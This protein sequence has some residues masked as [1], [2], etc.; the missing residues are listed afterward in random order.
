MMT[1]LK[2]QLDEE[3][4]LGMAKDLDI[5][6]PMQPLRAGRYPLPACLAGDLPLSVAERR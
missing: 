2:G 1:R 3:K 5:L 6:Y 4:I